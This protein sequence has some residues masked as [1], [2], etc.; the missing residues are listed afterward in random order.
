[1]TTDR[2]VAPA[3]DRDPKAH[4]AGLIML[5]LFGVGCL[6]FV[7]GGALALGFSASENSE[8]EAVVLSYFILSPMGGAIVGFITSVITHFAIK[9]NMIAKIAIP[10]I[11]AFLAVPC[12]LGCMIGFYEAIWP[13]L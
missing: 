5:A 10:P 8:S 6:I 13:S 2:P 7:C 11:A 1:M 9:Q 3:S 12:V 4:K